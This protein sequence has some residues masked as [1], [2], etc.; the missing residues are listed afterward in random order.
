MTLYWSDILQKHIFATK[1][2]TAKIGAI[3]KN[4]KVSFNIGKSSKASIVEAEA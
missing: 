2:S 1:E 3:K 4:N